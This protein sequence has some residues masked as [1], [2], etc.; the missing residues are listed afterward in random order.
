MSGVLVSPF[1]LGGELV[2]RP[3]PPPLRAWVRVIWASRAGAPCGDERILPDGAAI[4][5]FNFAGPIRIA[6]RFGETHL[7]RGMLA[8]SAATWA[9]LHY[10]GAAHE[11]LGI[12]FAPGGAS[13]WLPEVQEAARCPVALDALDGRLR[14]LWDQLA[15]QPTLAAR[16]LTAE[17]WL[18]GHRPAGDAPQVT[19]GVLRLWARAPASSVVQI[20]DRAGWTPQHLNRLLRQESGTAAKELQQVVRL[21]CTRAALRGPGELGML[22][23][24]LGFADQSH[25]HR[26]VRA[27]TGLSPTALRGRADGT[28]GRVI[29]ERFSLA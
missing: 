26:F 16:V 1:P 5:L 18:L 21:A 24:R 17:A 3:P 22:A 8:M 25:L 27:H 10:A 12:L 29:Y 4:L 7:G 11:Q 9:T 2:V 19:Q 14:T 6:H 28:D 20:A 23:H 13:A 15:H